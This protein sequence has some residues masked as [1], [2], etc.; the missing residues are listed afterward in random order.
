MKIFL[1][2]GSGLVGRNILEHPHATQHEWFHPSHKDLDLCDWESTSNF[3]RECQPDIIIHAAGK[4]GGIQ[5][6]IREPVNFFVMN[7]D[8]GRNLVL[9]ARDAGVPRFLNL[10]SSCMYPKDHE[11]A[12]REEEVL[13]GPLE[14]TNEGYALAKISTARLCSFVKKEDA[15]FDY[16]TLIPCNLYGR[17]DSFNP[18]NSHMIPSAIRKVHDAVQNESPE[19]EIWGDGTVRREFMYAGD[20]AD[21]IHHALDPNR[22]NHLPDLLNVGLGF[23]YSINEY[24]EEISKVLGYKG[25]FKHLLDKPVGMKRKLISTEKLKSWG[26]VAPTSLADGIQKTYDF[27]MSQNQ[28]A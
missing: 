9:G 24:Y 7:M 16:K 27:F 14:P 20:L 11:E 6:N 17:W 1:T 12:L 13:S 3:I 8:M 23:D 28:H 2:G 10:G 4:V 21:C 25:K 22:F 19:V 15:Q 26:W 5:A 18:K